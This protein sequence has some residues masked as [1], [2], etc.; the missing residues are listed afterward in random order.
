MSRFFAGKPAGLI[1]FK[2]SDRSRKNVYERFFYC[3][4][5]LVGRSV[6]AEGKFQILSTFK[7]WFAVVLPS[8]YSGQLCGRVLCGPTKGVRE[9]NSGR[10]AVS[11]RPKRWPSGTYENKEMVRLLVGC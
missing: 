10:S 4:F 2:D 8:I 3:L 5:S 1:F 7:S 9:A 6:R 11:W